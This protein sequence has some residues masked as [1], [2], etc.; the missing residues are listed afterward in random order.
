MKWDTSQKKREAIVAAF[1]ERFMLGFIVANIDIGR[2]HVIT[3]GLLGLG[4][5]LPTAIITRAYIPLLVMGVMGG[6]LIGYIAQIS[7]L[8]GA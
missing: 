8:Y 5:S 6:A 3:G 4:L 7:G 1:I 2:Y